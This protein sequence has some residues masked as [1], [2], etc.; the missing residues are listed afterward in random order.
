[1]S[2]PPSV[3]LEPLCLCFFGYNVT[4]NWTEGT[5]PI[6]LGVLA[7]N[8]S[9]PLQVCSAKVEKPISAILR[10]GGSDP[11]SAARGGNRTHDLPL[12]KRVLNRL[13]QLAIFSS[14]TNQDNLTTE[15]LL[16]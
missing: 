4:G 5:P 11:E 6:G 12:G 2:V 1:M 13:S 15:H 16:G 14:T 8:L 7:E 3:H 10:Y 9:H